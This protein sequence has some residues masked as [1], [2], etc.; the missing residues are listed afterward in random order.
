MS[1]GRNQ[2]MEHLFPGVKVISDGTASRFLFAG[3]RMDIDTTAKSGV[4]SLSHHVRA[5]SNGVEVSGLM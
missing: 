3:F 1:I 5:D 4:S 2:W